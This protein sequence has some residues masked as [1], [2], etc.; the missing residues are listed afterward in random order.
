MVLPSKPGP[1]TGV[2]IVAGWVAGAMVFFGGL[3]LFGRLVTD[4]LGVVDPAWV[5]T[6][7][8]PVVTAAG[9]VG[10]G[11]TVRFVGGAV[12]IRVTGGDGVVRTVGGT[13][14]VGTMIVGTRI[15][16]AADVTTIEGGSVVVA[17]VVAIVL[18][19]VVAIVV[20]VGAMSGFSRLMPIAPTCRDCG[21]TLAASL[22]FV[23]VQPAI[24][25][26]AEKNREILR[27]CFT[28]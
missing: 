1:G 26:A 11:G 4:G 28:T 5:T 7:A 17:I 3:V 12:T 21:A 19:I 24:T 20:V 14:T 6:V 13:M 16:G 27:S 15:V 2:G 22:L 10:F 18:A 8:G 9:F 23:F 25:S